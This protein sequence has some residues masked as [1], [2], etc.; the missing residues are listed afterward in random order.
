MITLVAELDRRSWA[1]P[2]LGGDY[3]IRPVE[4][5][6]RLALGRLYFDSY[7]PGV[8]SETLE[9][10][11]ADIDESLAGTYGE[12]WTEAS[13]VIHSGD[14][15]V[16]SALTVRRAPWDGVPDAPFVIEVFTARSHRRRGL[17]RAAL[18]QVGAVLAQAGE[19]ALG[20]RVDRA[21]HPA[22][23][24]YRALGFV[25]HAPEVELAAVALS[26]PTATALI[27]ELNQLLDAMYDPAENH[28]ALSEAEVDGTRGV[29]LVARLEGEPVGCGALRITDDGRGEVKR[30]YVRPGT[31]GRGVGRAI[32]TRLESEAR[33]RGAG[34]MVLEMGDRQPEAR[35]LYESAGY[36]VIPCWGEYLA[37]P[38]SVCLGKDLEPV[39]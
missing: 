38:T 4:A 31:Q 21:N 26:D 9:A 10:A 12:L 6:D 29:F 20:L 7:D 28:F 15:L 34:S 2:E 19:T 5:S 18:A 33:A 22:R 16:A 24:L 1:A 17:A 3:T 11:V 14:D 8:A 30:M 39:T 36:K 25:T 23:E 27:T 35:L 13:P 37:T 32:L